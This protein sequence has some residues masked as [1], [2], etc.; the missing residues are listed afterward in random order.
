VLYSAILV[1]AYAVRARMS[2]ADS[3]TEQMLS[4]PI[5]SNDTGRACGMSKAAEYRKY[6]AQ[7]MRVAAS[8]AGDTER[9]RWLDMAQQWTKWA[10]LEQKNEDQKE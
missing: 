9:G 5:V 6:A 1:T 2:D 3:F 8:A 4:P 7:C 10:E